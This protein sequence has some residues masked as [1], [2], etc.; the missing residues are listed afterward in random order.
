ME[1]DITVTPENNMNN[2]EELNS[3]FFQDPRWVQVEELI[4]SYINPL[5]EMKDIDTSQPAEAVKAEIIGRMIAYNKMTEFL[6]QS[7]LIG[8]KKRIIPNI[9][10]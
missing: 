6:E 1:K 4:L 2:I 7:K 10:K 8:E 5:L 3:V 9:F